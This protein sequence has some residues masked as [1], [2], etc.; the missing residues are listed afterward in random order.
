MKTRHKSRP[1]SNTVYQPRPGAR[2]DGLVLYAI[3]S[4]AG[5]LLILWIGLTFTLLVMAFT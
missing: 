2:P 3:D 5:L 1:F 4:M